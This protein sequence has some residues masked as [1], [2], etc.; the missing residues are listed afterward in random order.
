MTRTAARRALRRGVTVVGTAAALLAAGNVA[1]AFWSATGAGTAAAGATTAM[2]L[3][4]SAAAAPTAS[5]YP[6]KTEDL[7]LR[8]SNTNAYPVNLTRLTGA[9]V[10]SS[11]ATA[12][13][14][15]NVV[16]PAA[17][18]TALAT[19]G[20]VLPTP[21]SVLAGATAVPASLPGFLTLAADAPDGCQAKTFTVTL[22]FS[23][24]QVA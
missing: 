11:D 8:L 17:V 4:V 10:A 5:L 24:A 6:G 1:F 23:G 12:C 15:S 18:T 13:P 3:G 7:G 9:T 20:Y 16:L 14:A 2:P 22:N 21:I 19:G